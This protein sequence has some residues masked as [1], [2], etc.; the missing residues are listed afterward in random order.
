MTQEAVQIT[1][2]PPLPGLQLV[3]DM[4][5]ALETIATDFAGSTDPAAMAWAYSTWADTGT[6]TLKRRNDTNS[7]WVIEGRLLRAHL[8]MYAQVD[9]PAL[10]IGPIYI[11]GKGP[12]EWDG[13]AYKPLISGIPGATFAEIDALTEDQGPIICTDQDG[14]LYAW[15]AGQSEYVAQTADDATALAKSSKT[16]LLTPAGLGFSLQPSMTGTATF[17]K[18]TNNIE[19]TDIR[20]ELA[21]EVGDVIQISGSA[22]NDNLYT[23]ES[24]VDA[25]NVIVN[26]EH[27]NGAGSLSL[28]D[29]TET[30]TVKR[31]V[32]WFAAPIGLGR[33]PVFFTSGTRISGTAYQ[34]SSPRDMTVTVNIYT[35]ATGARFELSAD[36]AAWRNLSYSA[37]STQNT[38]TVTAQIPAGWYYR[39]RP[40]WV[41]GF[42]IWAEYR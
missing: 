36:G 3:Q 39:A 38:D 18:S 16:S 17:T 1:T 8:P 40:D 26:Y 5:K 34:N 25:D 13:V 7:A 21:L 41:A 28:T 19:L 30:V 31:V 6:G 12:A 20:D 27:R 29:E 11:I 24:I 4:N 33:A 23:V 14:I 15:D 35:N 32:K 42:G 37:T 22:D 2:T 9:V 10:D